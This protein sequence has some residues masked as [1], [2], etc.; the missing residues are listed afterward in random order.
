MGVIFFRAFFCL[1]VLLLPLP[2]IGQTSSE[3]ESNQGQSTTSLRQSLALLEDEVAQV[4]KKRDQLIE[5]TSDTEKKLRDLESEMRE[6]LERRRTSLLL[7]AEIE[8]TRQDLEAELADIQKTL[9]ED[10]STAEAAAIVVAERQAEA[11]QASADASASKAQL[12]ALRSEIAELEGVASTLRADSEAAE[13]LAAKVATLE[14]QEARATTALDGLNAELEEGRT[15]LNDIE[16]AAAKESASLAATKDEFADLM[17]RLEGLRTEMA[18]TEQEALRAGELNKANAALELK[19]ASLSDDIQKG[20]RQLDDLNSQMQS[21]KS[22]LLD[23]SRKVSEESQKLSKLQAKLSETQA[24]LDGQQSALAEAEEIKVALAAKRQ[25]LQDAVTQSEK[26]TQQLEAVNA[27]LVSARNSLSEIQKEVDQSRAEIARADAEL[28]TAKRELESTKSEIAKAAPVAQQSKDARAALNALVTAIEEANE[29]KSSVESEIAAI[30]RQKASIQA[31]I[32]SAEA[33][34]STVQDAATSQQKLQSELVQNISASRVTLSHLEEKA[35]SLEPLVAE[36]KKLNAETGEVRNALSLIEAQRTDAQGELNA[37]L[38]ALDTA[39]TEL[40]SVTKLIDDRSAE[41]LRSLDVLVTKKEALDNAM[42][43]KIADNEQLTADIQKNSDLLL[44]L[45]GD[46][47]AVRDEIE[48]SQA[49][50]ASGQ[51]ALTALERKISS[52]NDADKRLAD[53][54]AE[55]DETNAQL[56]ELSKQRDVVAGEVEAL[57]GMAA[58]VQ[59]DQNKTLQET[60]RLSAELSETQNVLVSTK[61]EL[62]DLEQSKLARLEEIKELEAELAAMSVNREA[63]R[64]NIQSMTKAL[65]GLIGG[66]APEITEQTEAQPVATIQAAV[67]IAADVTSETSGDGVALGAGQFKKREISLSRQQIRVLLAQTPGLAGA[68]PTELSKLTTE[69]ESGTCTVQA[70]QSAFGVVNRQTL[71]ALIREIGP[72]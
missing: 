61:N 9:A 50:Q 51:A 49:E 54:I 63:V 48:R 72:C 69:L 7:V 36:S 34:L 5:A 40:S 22:D 71:V 35:A 4:S 39:Q 55:T 42:A 58:K 12:T 27:E 57:Q 44:D 66:N 16:K 29:Q 38:A 17:A 70:L 30:T 68:A 1:I 3:I 28:V 33:D 6:Q 14:E 32:A 56:A 67:N 43:T 45:E 10:K 2:S 59:D 52:M 20:E 13:A 41:M 31:E 15:S 8:R 18:S 37:T 64:S 23:R 25:E 46:L 60:E 62:I 65:S 11:D 21:V 26:S 24:L 53:L 19:V 47:A